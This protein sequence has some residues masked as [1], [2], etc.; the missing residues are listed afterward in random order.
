[1]REAGKKQ[2]EQQKSNLTRESNQQHRQTKQ[3]QQTNKQQQ[4]KTTATNQNQR[5]WEPR[6]RRLA[7]WSSASALSWWKCGLCS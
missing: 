5:V 1:M 2:Q 4:L 3:Q 6:V 7:N